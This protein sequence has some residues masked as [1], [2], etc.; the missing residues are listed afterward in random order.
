MTC[1]RIYARIEFYTTMHTPHMY[2]HMPQLTQNIART[3]N[4]EAILKI[5]ESPIKLFSKKMNI[6]DLAISEN[7]MA[8]NTILLLGVY[9]KL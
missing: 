8:N 4:K 9:Q 2:I 5:L 6:L 3:N 7:P 1:V